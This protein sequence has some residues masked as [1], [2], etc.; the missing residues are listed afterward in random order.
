MIALLCPSKG[1]PEKLK[2]MWES[3]KA[4]STLPLKL[5]LAIDAKEWP[6]YQEFTAN[7][8]QVL[9]MPDLLPTAH[10][11][12]LLADLALLEKGN[13]LFFLAG[14]DMVFETEGWDR[15]MN[16]DEAHVYALQDSRDEDG[17]PHPIMTRKYIEAM[18][19]FVPPMFLHWFIDTW[20][21]SIA[22]ANQAFTHLK[23]FKLTHDKDKDQTHIGIRERGWHDRDRY[24]NEKM[25]AL[26]TS[27]KCRLGIEIKYGHLA[28]GEHPFEEQE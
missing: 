23:Q 20:T 19:Y 21:V 10:K 26:L 24:V 4:T 22:K 27:E 6:L 11:W 3:A 12:N 1:R 2:K 15:A 17:T 9:I 13:K 16:T 25:Q 14:D 8:I 7:N 28:L 18:G 5:Y